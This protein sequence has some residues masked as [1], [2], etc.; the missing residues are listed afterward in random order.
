MQKYLKSFNRARLIPHPSVVV[1]E[2]KKWLQRWF[3]SLCP[4]FHTQV[5][6]LANTK[7]DSK[8]GLEH[9]AHYSTPKYGCWRMRKVVA[10]LVWNIVPTIP[11]PSMVIGECEKW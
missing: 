7:S 5:W 11:H 10:K 3:G 6:L 4:L 9:C 8:V 1:G 2:Y